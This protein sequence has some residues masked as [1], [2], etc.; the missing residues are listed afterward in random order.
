MSEEEKQVVSE[1]REIIEYNKKH[2]L[3]TVYVKELIELRNNIEL[4]LDLVEKLKKENSELQE[5]IE[6]LKM[7][8]AINYTENSKLRHIVMSLPN[9]LEI[10]E[11]L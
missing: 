4:V 10:L 2:R 6:N 8:I 9:G 5:K 1:L 11:K 3:E 7:N